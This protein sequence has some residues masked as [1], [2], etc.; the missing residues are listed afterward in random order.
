VKR[1][2]M[3]LALAV[4]LLFAVQGAALAET[5][6]FHTYLTKDGSGIAVRPEPRASGKDRGVLEALPRFDPHRGSGFQVDLR[7]YDLTSLDL[8]ER[9]EDLQHSVFNSWTKWPTQ[10]PPDFDPARVLALNQTPGLGLR[11]LHRKGITGKGVGVAI[12]DQELLVSHVE[13]ADRLKLYE[14]IHGFAEAAEMH[15]PVVASIAVG[16]TVGVAPE[17]DLY[18]IAHAPIPHSVD[19]AALETGEIAND[20]TST[21]QAIR[22]LLEIDRKLPKEHKIRAIAIS[23]GFMRDW[24]GYQEVTQAIAAARKE[25]VF[26][27][28]VNMEEFYG[29]YVGGLSHDMLKDPE[30]VDSYELP[31]IPFGPGYLDQRPNKELPQLMVPQGAR[32]FAE[33]GGDDRYFYFG[34]G[35]ASWRP[36]F[37]AGLYA[38]ACQV[39]PKV[40]PEE[41]LAKAVETG[42]TLTVTAKGLSEEEIQTRVAEQAEAGMAR[43][44]AD[45]PGEAFAQKLGETYSKMNP[46]GE[47]RESM[48]EREFREWLVSVLADRL[49]KQ[50]GGGT[51]QLGVIANPAR[52]IESLQS[53]Q[54]EEGKSD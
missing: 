18:Y 45:F 12:I 17:A 27:T 41:F 14:E 3:R 11:E 16:K 29:V 25:G 32:T 50:G 40:T 28:C 39:K 13:Y 8:R 33:A 49:R 6:K 2:A 34:D 7:G 48:S 1:V 54:G 4:G 21:A 9:R 15:G 46:K 24:A 51:H 37:L 38:L 20:Y 43:L 30:A 31:A 53:A 5:L 44:K 47:K 42:D 26:V 52:L 10:L 19:E 22:R 23:L 35:G 36:P